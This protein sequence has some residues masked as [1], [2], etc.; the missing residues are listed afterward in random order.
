MSHK[1][2]KF[3][4]DQGYCNDPANYQINTRDYHRANRALKDDVDAYLLNGI[5]SLGSAIHSLNKDNFSWAFI[6]S[7]YSLFYLARAFNGINHYA[8]IYIGSKP[9]GI[10]IQ[11]SETFKKLKG[12]SHDVVLRQFQKHFAHDVLLQNDIEQNSPIEWFNNKRNFINYTLNPLT[13]P[14]PPIALYRY[15]GDLRHWIAAYINDTIHQYT[16]DPKH[17]YMAYP[18]QLFTRIFDFYVNNGL[19]NNLIDNDR[20]VF[21][22]RNF[23]D[24]KGPIA[25]FIVKILDLIDQND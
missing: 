1:L 4:N 5:I 16:F 21:F 24:S 8:I 18:V 10:K 25:P 9:Y 3:F 14:S 11:P 2:A 13:D 17:C 23:S 12:N 7:Y 19:T 15:K 6:Q 22:K 20:L